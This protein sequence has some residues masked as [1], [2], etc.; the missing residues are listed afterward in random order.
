[1]PY[2]ALECDTIYVT[3]LHAYDFVIKG[4][5]ICARPCILEKKMYKDNIPKDQ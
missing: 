1:M 4:G 5:R 3:E 2:G